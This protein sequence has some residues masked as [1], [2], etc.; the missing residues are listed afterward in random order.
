M[1]TPAA[2]I[3]IDEP[4]VA[5]LLRA[6]HP[7]LADLPLRFEASGRDYAIYRLRDDYAARLPTRLLAA[8]LGEKE[9]RWMPELA[10]RLTTRIPAPLRIG[11]PS[12]AF[13]WSW[14]ITRWLDGAVAQFD[15]A[16]QLV[17][18]LA[19][20]VRE[21]HAPA[22]T[23]APGIRCAEGRSGIG[24]KRCRSTC[25]TNRFRNRSRHWLADVRQDGARTLSG[26]T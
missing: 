14:S 4:L 11:V 18:D 23:D 17:T 20:F 6:Q 15:A 2:D 9:Q 25:R 24:T 12:A 5:R 3:V 16:G 13:P 8:G 7:D 26:R 21:L 19:R 1:D 10:D 22:P